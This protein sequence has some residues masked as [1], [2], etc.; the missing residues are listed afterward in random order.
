MANYADADAFNYMNLTIQ[1]PSV[2]QRLQWWFGS[3]IEKIFSNPNTPWLSEI[4]FYLILIFVVA[5]AIFYIIRLK[6]GGA[7]SSDSKTYGSVPAKSIIND[8]SQNFDELII[9][10]IEE[11]NF[12]LAI[13]YLYLRTLVFLSQKDRIKLKDWKSPYDYEKELD[14]KLIPVYSSLTRLFEY[15]WYGDADVS[16]KEFEEGQKLAVEIEEEVR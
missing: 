6:Y 11:K 1:P 14:R 15:A 8:K 4:L 7:I 3:M 2:W 13:R 5:A 10:A 16:S 12:R 9:S